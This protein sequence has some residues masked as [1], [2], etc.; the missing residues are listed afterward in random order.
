MAYSLKD[1]RDLISSA[2]IEEAIAGLLTITKDTSWHGEALQ[3]S[4]KFHRW[5]RSERS[6]TLSTQELDLALNQINT[7][8]IEIINNILASGL[9]SEPS[10]KPDTEILSNK[11]QSRSWRKCR[12]VAVVMI[13][14]FLVGIAGITRYGLRRVFGGLATE[15]AMQLTVYVHGPNGPQD[16]VLSNEGK[17]IVDFG[18]RRDSRQIGEDGRTNFGEIGRHFLGE[19][20]GMSV[21]AEGYEIS[22][23]DSSYTYDGEPIY[24]AVNMSNQLGIIQGKVR[25]RD[26]KQFLSNVLIE[27]AGETTTTNSLGNFHM[28]LPARLWRREYLLFAQK[29]GY[30][31]K[32]EKYYPNLGGIEI[33]LTPETAEE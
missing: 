1:I 25:S 14:V 22:N 16:I 33:R 19:L 13:I 11:S 24:L 23:P 28:E 6:G 17:L 9:T 2:E 7:A 4:A 18:N 20:I 12:I 3:Q 10:S 15:E 21:D 8:L 27:V 29:E 26:G 5:K 32:E 31:I 30:Q